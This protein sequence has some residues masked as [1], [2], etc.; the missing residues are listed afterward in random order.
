MQSLIFILKDIN[1]ESNEV[2][3][4]DLE[5]CEQILVETATPDFIPFIKSEQSHAF[6]EQEIKLSTD[7]T[8]RSDVFKV[9]PSFKDEFG[10]ND[11][12]IKNDQVSMGWQENVE[13]ETSVSTP[14]DKSIIEKI[15]A[16]FGDVDHLQKCY[17]NLQCIKCTTKNLSSEYRASANRTVKRPALDAK[18]R[19]VSTKRKKRNETL[20]SKDDENVSF[21]NEIAFGG[22]VVN[23]KNNSSDQPF[24]YEQ[25]ISLMDGHSSESSSIN[26]R[27][28]SFQPSSTIAVNEMLPSDASDNSMPDLST[29][30]HGASK[31]LKDGE[32]ISFLN[33]IVIKDFE[34]DDTSADQPI[35]TKKQLKTISLMDE[36][37][38]FMV[39]NGFEVPSN[40]GLVESHWSDE[41]DDSLPDF[42]F[43]NNAAA[44]KKM[45]SSVAAEM[46]DIETELVK[47]KLHDLSYDSSQDKFSRTTDL[48]KKSG[49]EGAADNIVLTKNELSFKDAINFSRLTVNNLQKT[50]KLMKS[51]I[52]N[53]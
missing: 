44:K 51:L 53:T 12:C 40:L 29:V 18:Y 24:V 36:T 22:F 17:V 20:R 3:C 49:F 8:P 26:T 38:S 11:L 16:K 19:S 23:D 32:N 42:S 13:F 9:S 30:I 39:G 4:K 35:I 27:R 15:L 52:R 48:Q 28:S 34:A 31:L 6:G 7:L 21:S 43:I 5:T 33:D 10:R 41:S 1:I 37:S 25:H 47:K 2:L 50:G 14:C 45:L 46:K